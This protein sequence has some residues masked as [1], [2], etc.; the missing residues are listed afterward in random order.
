MVSEELEIVHV[1]RGVGRGRLDLV[2]FAVIEDGTD[3]HEVNQIDETSDVIDMKVGEQEIVDPGDACVFAAATIRLASRPLPAGEAGV[4][5]KRGFIRE[6]EEGGLS[7]F[8]ID[9]VNLERGCGRLLCSERES[10]SSKQERRVAGRAEQLEK[11]IHPFTTSLEEERSD[12]SYTKDNLWGVKREGLPP[13]LLR[14][15]PWGAKDAPA[16][17]YGLRLKTTEAGCVLSAPRLN[18]QQLRR[19]PFSFDTP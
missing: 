3:G 2:A 16:S 12:Y 11:T 1:G 6:D 7:T 8:G 15:E 9:E 4:D 17:C 18:P 13:Q 10:A 19:Q 5:E 14:V